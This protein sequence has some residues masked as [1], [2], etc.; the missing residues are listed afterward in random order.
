MDYE[1]KSAYKPSLPTLT[2]RRKTTLPEKANH[3]NKPKKS[4]E[5]IYS[6]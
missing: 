1:V 4:Y 2:K 5:Q 6:N 3:R